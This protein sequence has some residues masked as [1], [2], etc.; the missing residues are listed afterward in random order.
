M[1]LFG[2]LLSI[3]AAFVA[4]VGYCLVLAK[5]IIRVDPLRRLMWGASVGVLC[6][7]VLEI[8]L[9]ATIGAVRS[10]ASIGPVFYLAHLAVFFLGTPALANVLILRNPRSTFPW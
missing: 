4:S 9:L 7:F 10:R 2:I 8:V 5:I 3:P 6:L 1:E